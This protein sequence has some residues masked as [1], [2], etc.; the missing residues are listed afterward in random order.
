MAEEIKA[1]VATEEE[2]NHFVEQCD[3]TEG[4]TIAVD[5]PDLKVWDQKVGA[6]IE[7][8]S[9]S[10]C[11]DLLESP[12]HAINIVKLFAVFT[13]IDAMVLYDVLHDPDYR[14]QWDENM[15]EGYEI[16]KLDNFNDVGY[17]S[18][19]VFIMYDG[20]A[21]SDHFGCRLLLQ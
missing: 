12:N 4:W 20:R 15:I 18:A 21:L 13:D 5:K 11:T 17:Y 1:K 3:T 8:N 2:F 9:L 14:K 7:S 16:E 19:K 10:F 6:E